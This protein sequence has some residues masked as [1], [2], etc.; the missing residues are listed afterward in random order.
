[1]RLFPLRAVVA[2]IAA[3]LV[4]AACGG[5][6]DDGPDADDPREGAAPEGGIT[7]LAAA[8]L[9]DAFDELGAAFADAHPGTSVE[10]AFGGSSDLRDQALAGAPADVF[11][12]A[13][14]ADA[15]AVAEG[16]AAAGE[17]AVFAT[18]RLAI[19][20]PAGNEAGVTGLEAFGDDDLLVGLCAEEVPCGALGRRALEAAGVTPAPDTEEPDVRSL[21]DKVAAGELDAGLVYVTDVAAAGDAVEAVEVPEQDDVV[22]EYAVTALAAA[23]EP[24]VAEAFVAFV[25]S[26]AGQDVLAAHGFGPPP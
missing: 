1:M 21:L 7:V 23:G 11:A 26:G 17:P 13:D 6:A 25:L 18:N 2:A 5:G 3:L 14:V 24:E 10:F 15:E 20:V 4:A 12:S 16:G 8:S 9:T 19:A 22:A